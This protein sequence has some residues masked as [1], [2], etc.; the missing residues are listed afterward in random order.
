MIGSLRRRA[1]SQT[2]KELT[3]TPLG[4]PGP[5]EVEKKPTKLEYCLGNRN[6][7]DWEEIKPLRCWKAFRVSDEIPA[8]VEMCPRNTGS[9]EVIPYFTYGKLHPGD[10][11][12]SPRRRKAPAF[13]T[14]CQT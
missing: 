3:S 4:G 2:S 12:G 8:S 6:P 5:G 14:V 11:G 10:E 9:D 13:L 7:R 1:Y